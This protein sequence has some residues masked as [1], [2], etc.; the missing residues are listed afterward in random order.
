MT[1]NTKRTRP[2]G[3]WLGSSFL[4]PENLAQ[5]S[6]IVIEHFRNQDRPSDGRTR[7]S[8]GGLLVSIACSAHVGD[9]AQTNHQ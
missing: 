9:T 4:H 3:P 2:A 6:E 1:L 7:Q 8:H 5:K